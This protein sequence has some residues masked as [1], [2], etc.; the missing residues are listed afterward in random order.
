M[1]NTKMTRWAM[2]LAGAAFVPLS[3]V[4]FADEVNFST[5]LTNGT[6]SATALFTFDDTDGNGTLT[7]VLTN[8]MS[9]NGGP[10]WLTGLFWNLTGADGLN[11]APTGVANDRV[12]GD[13]ITLSGTTQSAYNTADEGHFWAYR[14]DIS[15]GDYGA[16]LDSDPRQYRWS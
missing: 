9:T 6:Q 10:Q 16:F 15:S 8:T 13:M 12:E 2:A 3:G 7:V 11:I 4:A 5:S 14:D 1:T